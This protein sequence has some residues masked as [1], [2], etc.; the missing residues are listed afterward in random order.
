[1]GNKKRKR[2]RSNRFRDS[3]EDE[4]ESED[5]GT[6]SSSED[7]HEPI[8]KA[9]QIIKSP[10]KKKARITKRSPSKSPVRRSKK[11]RSDDP[12]YLG[13][14]CNPSSNYAVKEEIK[15]LEPLQGALKWWEHEDDDTVSYSKSD[16]SKSKIKWHT[17]DHNG[18]VFAPKYCPHGIRMKYDGKE[19]ELTTDQEE[20]A[21]MFAVMIETDWAQKEKFRKNFM[22]EFTKILRDKSQQRQFPEVKD[23]DKCDFRAI[24]D[25]Y[26]QKREDE[27]IKKKDPEY[28]KKI[29]I[30]K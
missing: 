18:V 13:K 8:V 26:Q 9:T 12:G 2:K 16:D 6:S 10:P 25:W 1:M 27:K 20:I 3:D 15:P 28:K 19:L 29:K 14:D 24:Y 5:Q 11:T 22:K 23:L 21:T 17:L 30:E 7:D 4:D